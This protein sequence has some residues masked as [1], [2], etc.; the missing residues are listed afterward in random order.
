[1]RF[2]VILAL[3]VAAGPARAEITGKLQ[4]TAA[5]E[6]RTP[7]Q[8]P[9]PPDTGPTDTGAPVPA[10]APAPVP[11]P[12]TPKP[13]LTEAQPPQS[14]PLMDAIRRRLNDRKLGFAADEKTAVQAHYERASAPLWTSESGL[15]A[16]G[17]AVL[18]ELRRADDY[19]L[20]ARDIVPKDLGADLV[21]AVAGE[22]RQ[23]SQT[24]TD[25]AETELRITAAVLDYASFA[26]GGRIRE[27]SSQLATYIDRA[28]QRLKPA[29]VLERVA[30]ASD[31]AEALRKINPQHPQFEALRRAYLEL[32]NRPEEAAQRPMPPGPSIRPGDR[33]PHVAHARKLMKAPT[34]AGAD[35]EIYD[36]EF[37]SLI[38][39]FQEAQD[40]VPADGIIGR[41]TR[42]A[43]S[44][45]AEKRGPSARELLV[46][47]EQWR[48]MPDDL[49]ETYIEVNLPEY[50]IRLKKN[51]Q[52]LFE[53]RIVAGQIDKQTPLFSDRLQTIVLNP[54]WI[55]PESVKV[56]EA[57]PSL[58]G[59]GNFFH[60]MGLRIKKGNTPV[61]PR[62]V[63]WGYVDQRH[64]TFFQPP[65]EKNALGKVK[66]LFPNKH[67]VYF[68]DTPTK[69]LFDKQ[70][71]A[72]SRG[73]VRVRD[74]IRLTELLLAA[75]R[76]WTP[77]NVRNLMENGDEDYRVTLITPVPIH[78]TYFTV[79]AGKDGSLEHF[80]DV[81]GHA[82]RISL[83]LDGRWREI[84]VPP[85]HL[86]P[87]EDREFEWRVAAAEERRRYEGARYRYSRS[88][89]DTFF[90]SLFGP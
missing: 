28:P 21:A 89:V 49:G 38:R 75:D 70:K 43:L 50:M 67:A 73:C 7:G 54:D 45:L 13:G 85:N 44:G 31:P 79:T 48:W 90:Q 24:L 9:D 78:I 71:R 47:M 22:G 6:H 87:I 19:G 5:L 81:Y 66:F 8:Y 57:I 18:G 69:Q 11:S 35:P 40:L 33:H 61:D 65:G 62:S 15:S 72:F 76:G 25:H 39:D 46:N 30:T 68:H 56:R 16:A 12:E 55:L 34:P 37:A 4:P 20:P 77:E 86:A 14:T 3:L 53:E 59:R 63:N 80:A 64:Y 23:R 10:P 58:L 60:S 74:P 26:R 88:P 41:K 27:P 17:A 2:V 51:G 84:D 32:R 42:A 1:M 52:V 36:D 83:A 82:K 29:V